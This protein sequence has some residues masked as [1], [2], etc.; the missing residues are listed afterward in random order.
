MYVNI[1][2]KHTTYLGVERRIRRRNHTVLENSPNCISIPTLPFI[3][4][5]LFVLILPSPITFLMDV[6]AVMKL[7]PVDLSVRTV[8]VD[9][10][11][12]HTNF[13]FVG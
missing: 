6:V 2:T 1:I 12:V 8:P 5:S 13:W 4:T 10:E 3:T 9:E 11:V 7:L